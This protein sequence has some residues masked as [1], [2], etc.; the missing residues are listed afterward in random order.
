MRADERLAA[1]PNTQYVT[2]LP[3]PSMRRPVSVKSVFH[4]HIRGFFRLSRA[5]S[6]AILPSALFCERLFARCK[7]GVLN[8]AGA[9]TCESTSAPLFRRE[10]GQDLVAVT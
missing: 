9:A 10:L 3:S 2:S 6:V 5:A 4:F 8:S 1:I 7:L